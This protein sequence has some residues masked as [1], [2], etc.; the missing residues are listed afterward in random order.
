MSTYLSA[1]SNYRPEA[2]SESK[3]LRRCVL[4]LEMGHS[5]IRFCDYAGVWQMVKVLEEDL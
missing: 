3:G 1:G 5:R 2:W 4:S